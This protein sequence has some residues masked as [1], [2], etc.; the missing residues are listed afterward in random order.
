MKILKP[1][2]FSLA[3]GCFGA[4]A[5]AAKN[6]HRHVG[7]TQHVRKVKR[8]GKA[9]MINLNK[10]DAI[11]LAKSVKGIGPTRAKA[12]VA[13]RESHGRFKSID[14]LLKVKG[15]GKGFMKRNQAELSKKL[16]F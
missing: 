10:V 3:I 8:V 6:P 14:D 1:L 7:Q 11:S 4:T 16:R 13:Y 2:V 15:I 12:I 9:N 5:L